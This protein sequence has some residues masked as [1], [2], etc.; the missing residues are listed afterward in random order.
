M[1]R[2]LSRLKIALVDFDL[3]GLGR[4]FKRHG[5]GQHTV[6]EDSIDIL[7]VHLTRQ[8]KAPAEGP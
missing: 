5:N 6:F 8:A 1:A 2:P 3:L 4:L 7:F